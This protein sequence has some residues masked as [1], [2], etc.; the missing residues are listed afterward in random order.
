VEKRKIKSF[1]CVNDKADLPAMCRDYQATRV[2][3]DCAEQ[4]AAIVHGAA[5]DAPKAEDNSRIDEGRN[6]C[7]HVLGLVFGLY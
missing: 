2:P 6:G 5:I 1:R 4:V 7:T 3:M